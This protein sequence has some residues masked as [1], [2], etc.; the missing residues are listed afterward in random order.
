MRASTP[1]SA[2]SN[3][4]HD[5]V[6]TEP[7]PEVADPWRRS[8]RSH[9]GV[10]RVVVV[11]PLVRRSLR[12]TLR[13]VLPVLLAAERS[14]VEIVPCVSHLLVAAVV[15]EVGAEDAVALADERVR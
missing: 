3:Q 11:P 10:V 5:D 6:V 9:L 1:P 2:G 12:V 15:D 7:R 14:D 8:P 13:R 4:G